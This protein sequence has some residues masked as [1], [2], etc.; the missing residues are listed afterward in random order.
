MPPIRSLRTFVLVPLLAALVGSAPF[1]AQVGAEEAAPAQ[2]DEKNGFDL[3]RTSVPA[4]DIIAGGP[5]RDG[6]RSVQEPSFADAATARKWVAPENPVIGVVIGDEAFAYPVHLMEHHQIVNQRVGSRA[7]AITYDPLTDAALAWDARVGDDDLSFGVS[8]LVWRSGF[9]MYDRASESLWSQ[10]LGRAIAGKR[11][12]ESLSRIRTRVE[13]LGVWLA[14]H[15]SSRIL[16]RPE[17][18][19]IDYRYSP[20]SA[21]WVSRDVVFPVPA[22]DDRYHPK[23]VVLGVTLAKDEDGPARAYLGSVLTKSGGRVVDEFEGHK[24][25]IAYDGE[26]GTFQF[27]A[28]DALAVTTAYWFAWKAFH[29]D[30][31]IWNDQKASEPA[32]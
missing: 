17:L 28:P 31:G 20:Y 25:R 29:P 12:G 4:S 26:T 6:I 10:M 19:Q 24:L 5:P 23:E 21:Y 9:L 27:D 7:V 18:K 8:G 3:A 1:G 13:P 11:T 15:P 16:E 14:R 22:R 32:E 30:T 2:A